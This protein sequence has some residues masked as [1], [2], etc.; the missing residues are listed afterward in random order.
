[1]EDERIH[2]RIDLAGIPSAAQRLLQAATYMVAIGLNSK[3]YINDEAMEIPDVRQRSNFNA[4]SPWSIPEAAGEWGAW[5]LRNGFRDISEAISGML[6]N[7]HAVLSY[8][9]LMK[10]QAEVGR[11][12]GDDWNEM[13]VRRQGSF[14]RKTLPQKM[15][16]LEKHYG[17][18]FPQEHVDRLKSLN[19]ARNCLVHR[20]GVVTSDDILPEE[21]GLTLRWNT[22]VTYVE[23][24]G[25]LTEVVPPM[26]IEGGSTLK[27]MLSERNK[28]FLLG[29]HIH[30]SA[31]EF[32][33]ISMGFFQLSVVCAQ[34]LKEH[35][36]RMGISFNQSA[37]ESVGSK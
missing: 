11:L 8:W 26:V 18:M 5:V 2:I 31:E 3:Q 12:V 17:F 30:V 15:D 13:V 24:E 6:E 21:N 34:L 14:H 29:E 33:E 22:L 9:S 19:A 16:F 32:G 7:T 10:N 37:S 28:T 36:M 35:G 20:Y 1:M 23:R 27:V 4:S 25:N